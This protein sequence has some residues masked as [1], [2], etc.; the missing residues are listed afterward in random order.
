MTDCT[1]PIVDLFAGPGGLGEGFSSLQGG[2]QRPRFKSVL[3]IECDDHAHATLLLRHFFKSFPQNDVHEDYYRFLR[4]E[5]SI[6]ELFENHPHRYE[7]A[8]STALKIRLGESTRKEVKQRLKER[9][10]TSDPW[11]LIGGPPCQAYSLVGR[12]RMMG[13]PGFEQDARH[14]L[15]KEY[16]NIIADHSPPVFVMEN[17]KGLL[18]ARI[19]GDPTINLI[20]K[21]L[22]NPRLA[23]GKTGKPLGYKLYS[24]STPDLPGEK[25]DP[26]LFLVRAEKYGVPQCRHRIFI[27][28][29]RED[30]KVRPG[31]LVPRKPPSVKEMIGNLPRLR[32]GISRGKDD[33][34]AWKGEIRK[35][36]DDQFFDW[37][38]R[39]HPKMQGLVLSQ[40]EQTH[41]PQKRTSEKCSSRTRTKHSVL[42]SLL[43]ERLDRLTLHETRA[44]MPGDLR[45]Y[46]FASMFTL[47][48]G[49]S[50]KLADF[51]DFLLP[52]HANVDEARSGVMFGDRFRVQ[53]GNAPS[54]TI[55]SHISKDGHYYIHYDPM[56]CRSLTV[57]EAARLQTFPDNYFFMGPRTEQYHQVGNAVPPYLARQIAEIIA[58]VLDRMGN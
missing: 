3:S 43:D 16:L 18:S 1:Y 21:D 22:A 57:R 5:L 48:E 14:F 31:Q 39:H 38:N 29:V 20:L 42:E 35:L 51:P 44:H 17:V 8:N 45:R 52:N 50:P 30:L 36:F 40:S 7:E 25:A 19:N 6:H 13:D 56:Q 55:T 11:A 12:S 53:R 10:E 26:G 41:Y 2:K 37:I 32:S 9:V 34:G 54:T 23:T 47:V 4:G 49:K 33:F 58:S 28:G 27:V 24:M 15:Y 46:C